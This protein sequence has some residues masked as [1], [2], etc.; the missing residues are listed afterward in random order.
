MVPAGRWTVHLPRS[1]GAGYIRGMPDPDVSVIFDWLVDGAP[2]AS[3]PQA[4][5]ARLGPGL[6]EAG[7]PVTRVAAFVRTLHP[8]IM[9]R[10]F[11]WHRGSAEVDI[12]EAPYGMLREDTYTKSPVGTVYV[13][14][15]EIR[16]RLDGS[17]PLDMQDLRDLAA[18]GLTDYV[19]LPMAFLDGEVHAITI[20]TDA[21]EG[22]SEAHLAGLRHIIRPLAR[23]AEILALRRTATNLLS[24]Y[25][26]RDAGERILRGQ[27]H[28]GD[29]ESIRC[30]LWFSDLR[31]FTALSAH[32]DPR[33]IILLL[34]RIF[35]CQVPAVE[36]AGGQVLK[37]MGDGM[38]A[39]FPIATD[40]RSVARAALVA[41]TEALTALDAMNAA[42]VG[43]P[44]SFG[45]ALHLGDVA[46]GNV[47]GVGRLDFTCIGPAVNFASRLESLTGRLGRRLLISEDVASLLGPSVRLLGAFELRGVEGEQ[48]VYEVVDEG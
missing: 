29:T 40:P 36:Q 42:A 10:A 26:G 25:V 27:V 44:L 48:N 9:G 31:G 14:G 43:P 24:A 20:A 34:N 47:G 15:K 2:G 37:F 16:R 1:A 30:V 12:R 23:L 22:F 5:V 7:I 38:L 33:D 11:L 4:V 19:V 41:A 46:Y 21:P 3:T 32:R 39:V 8:H 45:I 18:A 13:T 6:L 28:R 17:E 35:D